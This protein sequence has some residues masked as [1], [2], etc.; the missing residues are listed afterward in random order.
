V[1]VSIVVPAYNER[2]NLPGLLDDLERFVLTAPVGVEV[3]VVDDGSTDGTAE[4]VRRETERRPWLSLVAGPT[5]RGMGAALKLGVSRARHPLVAWVMADRSDRLAD[6]WEMRRRL[7]DGADLVVASRAIHGASYGE[8]GGGKALGSRA[9][10]L[11]ARWL[12]RLPVHDSTNA[13]RA[14][15]RSLLDEITLSHNDFA[16]S[17]ELVIK[18]T[19]HG[20]RVEET[21]TVYA[22]RRRGSST[23]SVFRMGLTYLHLALRAWLARL[24]GGRAAPPTARR[25][26]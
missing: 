18:A 9:F 22:F 20:R 8:L 2:E 19:M 25:G 4:L 3:L 16:I 12:L 23:F 21:P 6:I 1:D 10:S 11:F 17:P 24:A 15:R 26:T 5:N 14:F 7:I 13:F